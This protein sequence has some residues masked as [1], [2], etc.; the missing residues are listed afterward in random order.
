[1]LRFLADGPGSPTR[2][3]L[4]RLGLLGGG[5]TSSAFASAPRSAGPGAGKAKSVLVVFASGGQSQID[6]W[7]MKPLAPAEVRGVFRPVVTSVP[8]LQ[9]CEHLPRVARL[10]DRCT[11]VRSMSHD[12]LD[13]GSACYLALTGQR[14]PIK[15]SNPPP[16]PTDYPTIGALVRRMRPASRLP[17]SAVHLN[18][19]LLVPEMVGPGQNGGFLG[20]AYEPLQLGDLREG[21]AELR[22]LEPRDE[23]P[24]VRLDRRRSLLQN[25]EHYRR[26][27][28]DPGTLDVSARRRQA[29]ELLSTPECR[30]AFDL[31]REPLALRRR[32]GLHRAGQAC[33]LA[34]RLVEAGVPYVTAFFNASIRGQD[35]APGDTEAY[36]WDTH[37]DI[38]EALEG[39]LLPRFDATFSV[40]LED[41]EQRGLLDTTLVVCMGEFGRAPRV[42]LERTFAGSTPGRKH[43]AACYSLL[44]AGAGVARG[45][46]LGASDRY[47]AYPASQS[48][49]P[50]DVAATIFHALGM[51]PE[52][53]YRDA[54]DRPIRLAEGRPIWGVY[55]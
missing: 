3:E 40:L 10:M 5:F 54:L 43:W 53:H 16:R 55:G 11:L 17:Y 47:G 6:L 45:K 36:G 49:S 14:H 13:H 19:P 37:N 9:I 27:L 52:G 1:L 21:A 15:S 22:G 18:G 12:D 44:M 38:F 31:T 34:R 24:A 46:V 20:Q 29:Y 32:Y 33:L 48:Y 28:D 4:L 26:G 23:L 2:R 35:K 39:H 25:L 7:D 42:A 51:D 41:L 30:S 8:G 50:G